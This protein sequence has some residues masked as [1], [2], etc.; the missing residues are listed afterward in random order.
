M[1]K[2][3]G[4]YLIIGG[5]VLFILVFLGKIITFIIQNKALGLALLA[6]I[7]G[8]II[9]LISMIKENQAAKKDEPFRGIKV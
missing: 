1:M 4:L 9:L 6:I 3:I 5:V 7:A 2:N 8:V